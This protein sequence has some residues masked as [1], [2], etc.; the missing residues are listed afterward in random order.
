MSAGNPNR[1]RRERKMVDY[2]GNDKVSKEAKRNHEYVM[3]ANPDVG[4]SAIKNTT[5]FGRA[6]AYTP[7]DPA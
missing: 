7:L 4:G 3:A 1:A 6:D 5:G 2:T